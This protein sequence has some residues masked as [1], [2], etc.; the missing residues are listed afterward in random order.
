M[1]LKA[2]GVP[3]YLLMA[4]SPRCLGVFLVFF[5]LSPLGSRVGRKGGRGDKRYA[6]MGAFFSDEHSECQHG[7]KVYFR[8]HQE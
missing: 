5:F 8:R 6:C 1:L 4:L 2:S 3:Y 7:I